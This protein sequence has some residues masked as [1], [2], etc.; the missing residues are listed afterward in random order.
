MYEN[1]YKCDKQGEQG[2]ANHDDDDHDLDHDD[3]DD[4]DVDDDDDDDDDVNENE[5]ETLT[6]SSLHSTLR[7]PAAKQYLLPASPSWKSFL[8][9]GNFCPILRRNFSAD[10][11]C[12]SGFFE[13]W[14]FFSS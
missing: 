6:F 5:N 8:N 13:K 7:S 12:K 10:P 2:D 4:D 1:V 9:N 11:S 3:D 14:Q